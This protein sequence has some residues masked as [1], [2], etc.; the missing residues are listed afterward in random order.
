MQD[1][2]LK[3][4]KDLQWR[5]PISHYEE[6]K[7]GNWLD[8]KMG[9]ISKMQLKCPQWGRLPKRILK[10]H[11]RFQSNE[12]VLSTKIKRKEVQASLS[13]KIINDFK[14]LKQK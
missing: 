3:S 9:L 7:I 8:P 14:G 12:L 5:D 1:D 10:T 11:E 2:L 13:R 6:A 4:S